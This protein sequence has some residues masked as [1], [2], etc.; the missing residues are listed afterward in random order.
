MFTDELLRAADEN[1]EK[2][3]I[4]WR[5]RHYTYGALLDSITQ[6]DDR[7][8]ASGLARGSVVALDAD[9]SPEAVAALLALVGAGCVVV[10]LSSAI[11][12]QRTEFLVIAEIEAI[13]DLTRSGRRLDSAHGHDGRTRAA[14]AS[15]N[16]RTS[17]LDPLF[18]RIDRKEQG[19]GT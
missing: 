12:E 14:R 1:R 19:G 5:D 17:G 9:F 11:K 4:V 2:D 3:A 13:V 10:P 15:A 8:R 7:L 18:L 6:W 16:D